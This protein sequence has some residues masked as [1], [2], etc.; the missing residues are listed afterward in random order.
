LPR[1]IT[2]AALLLLLVG[3]G[4]FYYYDT[5]WLEPA[6]EKKESAKGRLWDFEPKDVEALTLKRKGETVRIKRADSGWELLEPVKTRADRGAVDGIVTGLATARVD[7]EVAATPASLDEFGLK[8]PEVEAVVEVKGRAPLGLLVGGKSPTGAWVF[9]KEPAKPAVV[10]LSEILA[11]DLAKPVAELRDR[12]VLAFDRKAV[13]QVDLALPGD[14]ISLESAEAGKWRIAKP[15]ALPAD[16]DLMTEFLEK[17]DQ[18]RVKEFVDDAPKSLGSYGLDR[19]AT[20]TLWVGKD[21][22]RAART[23]LFGRED[24]DKKGVYVMR[25]GESGVMLVPEELWVAVPKT[26]GVLRDKV[27]LAYQYDKVN[28]VELEGSRGSVVLEK[29]GT[30]WK[31]T[32][33]E[34]LKADTGAVNNMLW[35]I[36]DLRA[37]GF[38]AEEAAAIPRYLARPELTVKLWEEGAKE[39][40]V[41]LLAATRETRG[42]Q[43]AAAAAVAGQGPVMLVEGKALAEIGRTPAD[44]RDKILLPAFEMNDVKRARLVAAGKPLV[45]ERKGEKD[46]QMVEPSRGATKERKVDDFLLGLKILRWTEIASPRGDDAARFGLDKPEMEVSLLKGDGAEIIGLLVGKTE[47]PVTYVKLKSGPAVYAIDTKQAAD[48]R[49]APTEI[50]G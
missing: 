5:Y 3:L 42:G 47:G 16:T 21:K 26:V 46:W 44:L 32:A 35:K 34:T 2:V 22:E 10:A 6:R 28:R 45:V 25:A 7:R 36:R 13:S 49:K 50:P 29:D 43:P 48:I 27:V 17:L 15:R 9:G 23:L 40:R 20:V 12:T 33:P 41:L 11:R 19:P 8:T 1:W 24:K 37:V 31:I 18:A 4:G 39:P 14:V 30:G 38:L